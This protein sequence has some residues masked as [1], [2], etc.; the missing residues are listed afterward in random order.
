MQNALDTF[1]YSR[2]LFIASSKVANI[3]SAKTG[4]KR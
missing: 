4:P 3:V 2:L 1:E